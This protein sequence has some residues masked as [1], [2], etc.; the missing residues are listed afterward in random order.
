[1]SHSIGLPYSWIRLKVFTRETD[2]PGQ[3]P[4][5]LEIMNVCSLSYDEGLLITL[6]HDGN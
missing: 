6:I 1:M 3:R 2:F 4:N 5:L